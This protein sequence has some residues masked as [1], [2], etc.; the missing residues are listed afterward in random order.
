MNRACLVGVI[1]GACTGPSVEEATSALTGN[2]WY[3]SPAGVQSNAGTLA[4]PWP[5]QYAF[6]CAGGAIQPGDRV[7]LLGGTY[8]AEDLGR[9]P[10][11]TVDQF[12]LTCSGATNA[13]V[14]FQAE[15][16]VDRPVLEGGIKKFSVDRA[17]A[18][19]PCVLC[20][21]NIYR[22]TNTYDP[23]NGY[24]AGFIKI[25]SEWLTLIVHGNASDGL[26]YLKSDAEMFMQII[27]DGIAILQS[28]AAGG[29]ANLNGAYV[30]TG[31]SA[32]TLPAPAV[33]KGTWSGSAIVTIQGT[34]AS[35]APITETAAAAGTT[36]QSTQLFKTV[37]ALSFSAAVTGMRFGTYRIPHYMGPGIAYDSGRI[38]IRL[39]NSSAAA[40]RNRAGVI[41]IPNPDPRLYDIRISSMNTIG[42][43]LKAHDVVFDGLEI[44]DSRNALMY[45]PPSSGTVHDLVFR[46]LIVR[47]TFHG[48]RLGQATNVRFEGCRFEAKMPLGMSMAYSDVK[49][50]DNGA[51]QTRKCAVDLGS[52][53]NVTI[54][55]SEINEFFD[56]ILSQ[57][58]AHDIFVQHNTFNGCWDDAWQMYYGIRNIDIG[59][60]KFYGA[61]PSRD[62]T[63]TCFSNPQSGTVWI[64]HNLF[65]PN[66]HQIFWYRGGHHEVAADFDGIVD[67]IPLSEHGIPQANTT[68]PNGN[69]YSFPLKIYYNTFVVKDPKPLVGL[70]VVMHGDYGV[71]GYDGSPHEV[72]NNIFSESFGYPL[73]THFTTGYLDE[74]GQ[75]KGHE[76]YDGNVFSGGWHSSP[77]S[78]K[79]IYRYVHTS[80]GTQVNGD[81][82]SSPLSSPEELRNINV[83]VMD[84][85]AYQIP[86]DFG[87][88]DRGWELKG[89][90]IANV[91]FSTTYHPINCVKTGSPAT[92]CDTGAVSL[93]GSTWPGT[94]LY[95]PWRGAVPDPDL[96]GYW[97]FDD[98][99]GTTARDL[100]ASAH[101][102]T[103]VNGPMWT[104]GVIGP[105]ALDFDDIDDYVS[106][107]NHAD[108][109]FGADT[110]F[111]IA[112]WFRVDSPG[113]IGNIVMKGAAGTGGKRYQVKTTT[114][115]KLQLEVDDDW[116]ERVLT[117]SN[118]AYRIDDG[119]WHFVAVT[120][121]R[122]ADMYLYVDGSSISA[123]SSVDT[124]LSFDDPSQPLKIGGTT[125]Y[126][127]GA[128]DSVRIYRNR[129]LSTTEIDALYSERPVN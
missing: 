41:Q 23:G 9:P 96:V 19:E 121:D 61:G 98:G 63:G 38:Y 15:S 93:V 11:N 111:S 90:S 62:G 109:N 8:W 52:A 87:A 59:Y 127:N 51:D 18:W 4:S 45:A 80:N 128:I 76:M 120:V 5:L 125:Q 101:D 46:N 85:S 104:T 37:T 14:T 68:C 26:L 99:T 6:N 21:H 129:I 60:N 39:D 84:S 57:I 107:P 95:Q 119:A 27:P 7:H 71:Q 49:G 126:F 113:N 43:T 103:L 34:N 22:S 102:G 53:S 69:P 79:P 78:I 55:N 40:Q 2:D 108:F 25:G 66:E 28:V 16:T 115:G 82:P 100:S 12:I 97:S 73:G 72:Y 81:M 77:T 31:G 112:A 58:N 56:G 123:H 106:V 47:P 65:A 29:S 118:S 48:A 1:V 105:G 89:F 83:I 54:V 64:H 30:P 24:Y 3:V 17:I 35:G 92:T 110:N 33:I 75:V 86:N 114:V 124:A 42:V 117:S 88:I 44:A 20:G 94:Q 116:Q 13:P 36:Y 67:A 122:N 50:G 91:T 74:F 32:A 10:T 70:G